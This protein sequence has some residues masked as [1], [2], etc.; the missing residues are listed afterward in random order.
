VREQ[1]LLTLEQAVHKMTGLSAQ[2][3]GIADRGVIK[4]GAYADLVL[5]DPASVSDHSTFDAPQS[6]ST[7]VARVWVNGQVV[8]EDGRT[9]GTHSGQVVRRGAAK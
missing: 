6:L 2:H 7:G 1:K 4:P 8:L 5:F 9:T 3:V